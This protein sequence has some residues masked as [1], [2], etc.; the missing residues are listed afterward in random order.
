MLIIVQ[1]ATTEA[2]LGLGE[3]SEELLRGDRLPML[4]FPDDQQ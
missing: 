2:L 4:N 3:A 1:K